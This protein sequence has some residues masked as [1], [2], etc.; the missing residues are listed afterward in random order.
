M[1]DLSEQLEMFGLD[2][3][4]RLA[5]TATTSARERSRL[6]RRID[7]THELMSELP[8]GEDLSF[9]HSGLCQTCLPHSRPAGDHA[10]W[11]RKS[12]RFSLTVQ[13]GVFDPRRRRAV[14]RRPLRSESA[15][16][17]DPPANRGYE[18]PH[19]QP[20]CVVQRVH[21]EPRLGSHWRQA[22]HNRGG[23]GAVPSHL[24]MQF[25]D[26]MV[27]RHLSRSSDCHRQHAHRGPVGAVEFR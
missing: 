1:H 9:L 5:E 3:A 15:A 11:Q 4:R 24:P 13:P 19:G 14:R 6:L 17:P 27:G 22:W 23:A 18:V 25:Y 10:V 20:R 2:R 16:D 12:G 7:V 21:A 8:A 26:A